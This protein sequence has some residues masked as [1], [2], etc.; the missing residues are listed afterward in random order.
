MNQDETAQMGSLQRAEVPRSPN[1]FDC[2]DITDLTTRYP[3]GQ[4]FLHTYA[5]MSTDEL[6]ARQNTC[7]A[8][9]M[10]FAWRVPFYQRLWGARG[11]EPADIQS[12]DD[13]PKLPTY[14]K[15]DLMRSVE[16]YPPIGDFHGLESYADT[17]RPPV[18]LQTTSGTT[19]RPQPLLCGPK[20]REVQAMLL[21]RAYSFQGLTNRDVIHSVYGHGMVNGGHYIREAVTHWIGAQLLTAG[22]GIETRS[23]HQV[24]LM[25][26]FGIT[27]IVGFADFIK[28]LA[29]V[30]RQEGL[31][32]GRDIVPRVISC[33]LGADGRDAV[34]TAWG[35]AAV[36][37]WYGVGD[38]G[39]IASEG[40]DQDG[41]YLMEDA[42]FVEIQDVTTAQEAAAGETGDIICTCLYKDDV[43]PI[44]RFNTHDVT[45]LRDG[46][47]GFDLPFR[48]MQGFLGRS[49]S[50]VKLR[51]VNVFPQGIGAILSASFAETNGEFVCRLQSQDGRDE[52]RVVVEASS[53]SADLKNAMETAL[54]SRLGVALLVDLV[55]AGETAELTGIEQ[56]QK[57][58]RLI[59]ERT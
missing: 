24:R 49:D 14:S 57:P 9:V 56:R 53:Q 13:L 45:C 18:I 6:R 7:F 3:V 41:L 10:A 20:S 8:R 26:D 34:A 30:A 17:A 39:T 36:Y 35:G 48:R 40:P 12:L 50:M 42:H 47:N 54:R 52:M 33:H 38:T 29:D 1:Y 43:F 44:I 15:D 58:I 23:A 16:D 2:L 59:D 55:A 32:P 31:E 5:N 51:G 37:D 22:T 46:S 19:G 4:D 11:L 28:R 25:K 27:A 21:G